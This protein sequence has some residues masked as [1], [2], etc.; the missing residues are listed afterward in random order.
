MANYQMLGNQLS[1]AERGQSPIGKSPQTPK[2]IGT[3][4]KIEYL[5][6]SAV[7]THM[8]IRQENILIPTEAMK[9]TR[10]L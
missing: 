5:P 2:K 8:V 7:E 1:T 3:V 9:T 6:I 10:H 4:S